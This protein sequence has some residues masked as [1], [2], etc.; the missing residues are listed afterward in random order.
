MDSFSRT[1]T[2]NCSNSHLYF[3]RFYEAKTSKHLIFTLSSIVNIVGVILHLGIIWY[4]NHRTDH[5]STLVSRLISVISWNTIV[6]TPVFQVSDTLN[7]FF[8]PLSKTVCFTSL[9]FRNMVKSNLLFF[10]DGIIISRYF[11]IFWLKNPLSVQ[12]DFWVRFIAL[13]SVVFSFIL[14]IS[15]FHLPQKLS[16][17]YYAC[18]DIDPRPD[19]NLGSKMLFQ[20]EALV[21]LTLHLTIFIKIQIFKRRTES[22]QTASKQNSLKLV[23][24]ATSMCL[25]LWGGCY[26][27][28]QIKTNSFEL[29]DSAN[30][31][32]NFIFMYLYQLCTLNSTSFVIAVLYYLNHQDLR[33]KIVIAIKQNIV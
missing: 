26:S 2:G 7:Y 9:V 13:M 22:R 8:G 16:V 15:V 24:F 18:A 6:S 23:E 11:L 19:L 28:L 21:A 4:E 27:F 14:N 12:D 29:N 5:K 30:F 3:C 10:L 25:V 31:N 32:Q 33:K 20:T 17:F 1:I